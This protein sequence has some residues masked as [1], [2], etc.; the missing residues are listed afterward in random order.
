[1]TLLTKEEKSQL[2]EYTLNHLDKLVEQGAIT[3]KD[4]CYYFADKE[5]PYGEH[6][7]PVLQLIE[8]VTWNLAYKFYRGD[9]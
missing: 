5:D 7:K 4:G 9:A 3:I 1:M 6:P 2:S 8:Y